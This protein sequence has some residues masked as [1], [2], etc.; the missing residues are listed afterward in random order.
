MRPRSRTMDRSLG[1]DIS[2]SNISQNEEDFNNKDKKYSKQLENNNEIAQ[3][4]Y[5]V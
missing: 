5:M 2:N 4:E 3:I 1:T